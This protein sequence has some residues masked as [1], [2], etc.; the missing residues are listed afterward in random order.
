MT[1]ACHHVPQGY[2]HGMPAEMQALRRHDRAGAVRCV[3]L[4]RSLEFIRNAH[5]LPSMRRARIPLGRG[6]N[7]CPDAGK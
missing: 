3:P 7:L 2:R 5:G 1:L 6:A 4:V